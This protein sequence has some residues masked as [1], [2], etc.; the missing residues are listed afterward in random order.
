MGSVDISTPLNI[1]VSEMRHGNQAETPRFTGHNM[2]GGGSG[3]CQL[4]MLSCSLFLKS[5]TLTLKKRMRLSISQKEDE[6]QDQP[7]SSQP[8]PKLQPKLQP[9]SSQPQPVSSQPQPINNQ[10]VKK[11]GCQ[12]MEKLNGLS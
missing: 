6:P 2:L 4:T 8:Q 5:L 1:T 12:R 3:L 7:I 10:L 11:Y 9:I